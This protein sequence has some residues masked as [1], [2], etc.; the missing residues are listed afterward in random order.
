[1]CDNRLPE[2]Q[3]THSADLTQDTSKALQSS[4]PHT[5]ILQQMQ[6]FFA[7]EHSVT[8]ELSRN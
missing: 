1:M 8:F 6:R 3:V 7:S 4:C 2:I 5:L